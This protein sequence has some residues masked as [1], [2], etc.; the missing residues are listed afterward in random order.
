MADILARLATTERASIDECY[1]DLGEE[2]RRRMAACAGHPPLPARAEQVH[3]SGQVCAR[4]PQRCLLARF[5]KQNLLGLLLC[6]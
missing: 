2:A 6:A 4:T 5:N 1:L 3:V